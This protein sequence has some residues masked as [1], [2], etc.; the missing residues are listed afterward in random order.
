M[1]GFMKSA[2]SYLGM[3]DVAEGDEDFN[4][5][6][7]SSEI[8]F[9]SD[10]SVD[11]DGFDSCRDVRTARADQGQ[12]VPRRKGEPCSGHDSPEIL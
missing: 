10:H 4:E 2:M 9:D 11:P 12:P 5:E 1:A 7:E 3:T 6:A 8:S